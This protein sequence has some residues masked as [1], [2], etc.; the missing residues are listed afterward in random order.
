MTY[1]TIDPIISSWA[2]RRS[3]HVYTRYEDSEV[4]SMDIVSQDGQRFQLWIDPPFGGAIDIHAW[5]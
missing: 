2:K 3:L 5:D 4:R 1:S